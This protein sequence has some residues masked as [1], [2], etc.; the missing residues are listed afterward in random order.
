MFDKK[1]GG[2]RGERSDKENL[3]PATSLLRS[4]ASV[5]SVASVKPGETGKIVSKRRKVLTSLPVNTMSPVLQAEPLYANTRPPPPPPPPHHQETHSLDSHFLD[6]DE[7]AA[8]GHHLLHHLAVW[9][10][11]QRQEGRGEGRGEGREPSLH[12]AVPDQMPEPSL[13]SPHRH[14]HSLPVRRQTLHPPVPPSPSRP[15]PL[16]T[17]SNSQ[18]DRPDSGFDSKD[19]EGREQTPGQ[20]EGSPEIGEISRQAVARQPVVKKK[21]ILHSNKV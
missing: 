14:S 3:V 21:R 13:A 2:V 18:P 17:K 8:K 9:M 1:V 6:P 15:L 12:P 4:P 5:A 10:I 11:Q 19:E 7:L 16:T 20:T